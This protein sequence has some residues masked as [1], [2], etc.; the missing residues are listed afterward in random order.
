MV[1]GASRSEDT[2]K[3]KETFVS[4]S[5]AYYGSHKSCVS[6]H[7]LILNEVI[8]LLRFVDKMSQ[9]IDWYEHPVQQVDGHLLHIILGIDGIERFVAPR[10]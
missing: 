7:I 6:I 10:G 8:F 4:I 5:P 9:W 1:F 2:T 3:G